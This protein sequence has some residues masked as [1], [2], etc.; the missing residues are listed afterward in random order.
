MSA[1]LKTDGTIELEIR[2]EFPFPRELVF[3][4]WVK[5]EHLYK[6]MGPT[7]EITMEDISVDAR[8]GGS[9]RMTYCHPDGERDTVYGVFRTF[10]RPERLVF[11]WIW[12]PETEGAGIETLVT[13]N[14]V[15]TSAG[16]EIILLHQKFV[17]QESCDRHL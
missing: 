14:F 4:A 2:R 8:E 6:W 9:Y 13:V 7:D 12:E 3:D 16:A 15:K 5:E 10:N 11:T 1:E 17:S